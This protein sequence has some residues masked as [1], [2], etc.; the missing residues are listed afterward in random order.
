MLRHNRALWIAALL[1]AGCGGAAQWKLACGC[2]SASGAAGQE[3]GVTT[4]EP[5]GSIDPKLVVTKLHEY[6]ERRREVT[7]T[8]VAVRQLGALHDHTC[9][10]H[11][12]GLVRCFYWFWS[13]ANA[14]RGI[15][16][17]I[18]GDYWSPL[19]KEWI[20]YKHI[21]EATSP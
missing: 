19:K 4:Y 13:N 7:S 16:V 11:E 14:R 21:E 8:L 9:Y 12:H 6:F 18:E 2:V 5:D 1:A 20:T 15:Q 3:L 17:D 10:Q